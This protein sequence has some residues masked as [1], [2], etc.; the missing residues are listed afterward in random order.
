MSAFWYKGFGGKSGKIPWIEF[1]SNCSNLPFFFITQNPSQ[2]RHP[3]AI[4][5]KHFVVCT[6]C[7]LLLYSKSVIQM[8][9]RNLS[10]FNWKWLVSFLAVSSSIKT[11]SPSVGITPQPDQHNK[12]AIFLIFHFY[13]II[14]I[15]SII[16]IIIFIIIVILFLSLIIDSFNMHVDEYFY[17]NSLKTVTSHH[18]HTFE[19][20]IIFSNTKSNIFLWKW[21][22]EI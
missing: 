8:Y 7:S 4:F 12:V 1:H 13:I 3:A 16:I 10:Y 17:V 2:K 22:K 9:Q 14:I 15:V 18:H 19:F 6:F 21:L 5:S 20:D 11:E